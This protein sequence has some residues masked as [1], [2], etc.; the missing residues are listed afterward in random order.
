MLLSLLPLLLVRTV[1]AMTTIVTKTTI[2]KA[3][4]TPP[5]MPRTR[6]ELTSKSVSMHGTQI[7]TN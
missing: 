6:S 1:S 3:P 5:T 7:D 2:N 4:T